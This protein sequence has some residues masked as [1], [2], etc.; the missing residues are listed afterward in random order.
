MNNK[1][2]GA[3]FLAIPLILGLTGLH[4]DPIAVTVGAVV[5]YG[6]LMWDL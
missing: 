5:L 1:I 2:Q 3:V 6:C 4:N